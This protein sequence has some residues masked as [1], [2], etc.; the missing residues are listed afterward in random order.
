MFGE[1]GT[2]GIALSWTGLNGTG[3][4]SSWAFAVWHWVICEGS[5]GHIMIAM[6]CCQS[7]QCSVRRHAEAAGARMACAV[8]VKTIFA[9]PGFM[10]TSI[11][12]HAQAT[13][14][15]SAGKLAV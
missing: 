7:V 15:L 5:S 2:T 8:T 6:L 13:V 9:S 11:P 12:D 14:A 10:A 3:P 4:K 1:G